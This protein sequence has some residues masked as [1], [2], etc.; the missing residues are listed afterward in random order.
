[1]KSDHN[2]I[3]DL[4]KAFPPVPESF[5]ECIRETL[6]RI[7]DEKP[8]PH[9]SFP[10]RMILI[11]VF[12]IVSMSFAAYALT[13]IRWQD[14][15]D[16]YGVRI[17]TMAEQ[18]LLNSKP[19]QFD[20]GPLTFALQEYFSDGRV[21]L[22]ATVVRAKDPDAVFLSDFVGKVPEGTRGKIERCTSIHRSS[23][24]SS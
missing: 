24:S 19:R 22:G 12:I 16:D 23:A 10:V 13:Q 3:P 4:R 17:T 18:A 2:D 11:A 21:L 6:E 7:A 9:R 1:M 14:L 8:A 5:M 15:F 20:V